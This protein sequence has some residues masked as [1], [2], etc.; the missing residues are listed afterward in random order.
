MPNSTPWWFWLIVKAVGI[1]FYTA[2]QAA[3]FIGN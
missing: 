1:V 3:P 2:L